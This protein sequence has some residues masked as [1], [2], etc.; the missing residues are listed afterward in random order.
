MVDP[1]KWVKKDKVKKKSAV[2]VDESNKCPWKLLISKWKK[3][4]DWTVKMYEK[5][6]KCLQKRKIKA[7]NYKFLSKQ[8]LEQ[9]ESNPEI[10]IRA[11]KEQLERIYQIQM[12]DMKVFREKQKP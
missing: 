2:K 3:V 9:L 10:P 6:H 4:D 12:L 8:I 11:L 7:C 5:E 1:I